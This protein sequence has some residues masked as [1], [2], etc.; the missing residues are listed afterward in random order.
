M[1]F[2]HHG[3][4][5][6]GE[7]PGHVAQDAGRIVGMVQDHRDQR[8]IDAQARRRQRRG[9]RGDALDVR[10]SA[11]LLPAFE[12]RQRFGRA[13]DRVYMAARSDPV[14]EQQ[15]H[16]A[17]PRAD[18]QHAVARREPQRLHPFADE[19]CARHLARVHLVPGEMTEILPENRF[20][21]AL[22][23]KPNCMTDH[24]A[25][26]S[27]TAIETAPAMRIDRGRRVP[28]KR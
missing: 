15:G 11:F 10:Y 17:G 16:I 23:H 22:L 7:W 27:V 18:L 3:E 20:H 6:R 28:R 26:P 19:R 24:P 21:R 4:A 12:M 8:R 25:S 5:L 1:E 2:R 13:V 14:G 9:V